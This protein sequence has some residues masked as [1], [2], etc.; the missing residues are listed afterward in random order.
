MKESQEVIL[1]VIKTGRSELDKHPNVYL[2][3]IKDEIPVTQLL[4]LFA[5]EVRH[6]ADVSAFLE[7]L[8][9]SH[10][11]HLLQRLEYVKTGSS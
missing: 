5:C 10:D 2:Y 9:C 8:T 11:I 3:G 1:E 4:S 6:G 7:T